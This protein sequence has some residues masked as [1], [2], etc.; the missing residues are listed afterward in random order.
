[1]GETR[2]ICEKSGTSEIGEGSRS[3]VALFPHVPRFPLAY[4][5]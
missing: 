4:E 1:M 3:D 2:E 5:E